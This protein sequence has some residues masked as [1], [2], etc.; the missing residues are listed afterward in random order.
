MDPE[1]PDSTDRPAAPA[2]APGWS[3]AQPPPYRADPGSAPPAPV[4]GAQPPPPPVPGAQP[5]WTS[6]SGWQP[7]PPAPQ[8]GVVPLRPLGVGEIITGAVDYVRRYPKPVLGISAVVGLGAAFGQLAVLATGYGEL[9]ALTDPESLTPEQLLGLARNLLIVAV[10]QATVIGL[11]QVLG[12]GML[13]HIMNR[14]TIGQPTSFDQAWRLVRPQIL[15]LVVASLVVGA[16]VVVGVALPIVPGV[17]ALAAGAGELGGVLIGLGALVSIGLAVWLS[18][19][20]VLTTPAVAL[21]DTGVIAGLRRSWQLVG[22]AFW[23]TLGI[24]LLGVVLG[25]AVGTVAAA[26]FNLFAGASA[27]LSTGSVFALALSGMV[28]MLVALPFIAGVTT[29]VY[30]DRRMRAEN[31]QVQLQQDAENAAS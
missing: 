11:L 31:Y 15:R 2:P 4:A 23:R 30:L 6:G 12:T 27:E 5:H 7:P 17:V 1:T 24:V 9:E 18:F 29:L 20:L 21:E 16:I 13:A 25:Q 19:R 22:G 10:V 8:P 28:T 14:A 3:A 26:P